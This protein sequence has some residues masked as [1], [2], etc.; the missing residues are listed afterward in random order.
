MQPGET[1][2]PGRC[3]RAPGTDS[4]QVL[5]EARRVTRDERRP[6]LSLAR[7]MVVHRGCGDAQLPGDVRVAER[8]EPADLDQHFGDV[9]DVRG[10]AGLVLLMRSQRSVT[11]TGPLGS[12]GNR[13]TTRLTY[14]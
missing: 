10:G 5:R 3:Q 8:V 14:W 1:V 11:S 13:L 6:E 2:E 9:E 12:L 7:E 4:G